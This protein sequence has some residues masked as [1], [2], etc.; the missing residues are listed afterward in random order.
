MKNYLS[1]NAEFADSSLM[2]DKMLIFK[3]VNLK[4]FYIERKW[5]AHIIVLKWDEVHLEQVQS[6]V[7]RIGWQMELC[8]TK[9]KAAWP[10]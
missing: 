5:L 1:P 3:L 6:R 9:T 8:T 4:D 7:S 2:P 10:I